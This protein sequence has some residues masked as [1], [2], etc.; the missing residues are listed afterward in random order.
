MRLNFSSPQGFEIV[1][2]EHAEKTDN[3]WEIY[4]E[5]LYKSIMTAASYGYPVYITENGLA[6]GADAKR[7]KFN[8]DHLRE[9]VFAMEDGAD[10]RGYLHWSLMDNWEWIDGYH[11][12]FGLVEVDLA[13]QE[14]KVR[15][16]ARVL[17]DVIASRSLDAC[18][19]PRRGHY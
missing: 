14:R 13:T 19:D 12:K 16:S 9:M 18:G 1:P 6:D 8:C 17:A 4:P 10:V 2:N 11:P 5:G 3:E 7:A 15:P